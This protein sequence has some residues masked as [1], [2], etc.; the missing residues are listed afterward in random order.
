MENVYVLIIAILFLLAVFDLM[1]GV[2]NDAVNFLNSAF[3]SKVAPNWVILI[4]ASVGILVGTT[5]SSGMMEVARKGIFHPDMFAYSEIMILFLAVMLTDIILLDFYNTVALPT[6]TTVSIVF[7]LLGASVALALIKVS[8]GTAT[9]IGTFI[10]TDTA[11]K[12]MAGILLSVA[13]AF[14]LGA[15][16]QFISRL[17]F[18]FNYNKAHDYF[19]AIWGGLAITAITYFI[20]IKG[21]SG[22][23]FMTEKNVDWIMQ[24]TGQIIV[25]SFLFW[26]IVLQLLYKYLKLNIFKAIIFLG[27]FALALAFASNDLVNFIGVPLAGF[28]SFIT[29]N[30]AAGGLSPDEFTME[31]LK[32]PVQSNTLM[33]LGA[34]IIMAVTL[35]FSGKAR[36]VTQTEI[37][38]GRQDPGTE[39]FSSNALSRFI[40]RIFVSFN[41]WLMKSLPNRLVKRLNERFTSQEEESPG[42]P[43]A[44]FDLIRASVNLTV[45][46]LIISFATSLKMPLSTTYVAF[47][48]AMGTS[49]SDGAW[50]RESAAYRISG[51]ITV[52][53]GWFLTAIIGFTVAFTVGLIIFYGKTIAIVVL[54]ILDIIFII[55]T[56]K[57]Q[58]TYKMNITAVKEE[59][60]KATQAD[61]LSQVHKYQISIKNFENISNLINQ[62][63]S[64]YDEALDALENEDRK[65]LKR[66]K[67]KSIEITEESQRL[68]YTTYYIEIDNLSN[69]NIEDASYSYSKSIDFLN[70][71]T[72][73]LRTI[74]A[75]VWT[76]VDNSHKGFNES[77]KKEIDNLRLKIIEFF[78]S[79]IEGISEQDR[80][81]LQQIE[82]SRKGLLKE[83]NSSYKQQ[84]QR[85]KDKSVTLRN[86]LLFFNVLNETKNMLTHTSE[87]LR[88]QD[89]FIKVVK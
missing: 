63:Y 81:Q 3:G 88:Y 65:A 83:V 76:H 55:R 43:V 64:L 68:R 8:T 40:V 6:S 72:H 39:R 84:I 26:S 61:E 86:S 28:K 62:V 4:I 45:A 60:N 32:Q 48:V 16:V 85:I 19:A 75:S 25:Y 27:T 42:K 73:S 20:V 74:I 70:E 5:F 66:I 87:L 35:W 31:I 30:N 17:I 78:K 79:V 1:V 46:S 77:Q 15:I 89:K 44:A 9:D 38:L 54:L 67:N 53:G 13:I 50:G 56:Y 51:V 21:A 37:N 41:S 24:N 58:I 49:L 47:M 22:A 52:I 2:S 12:I 18:S 80:E 71:I 11:S 82:E 33:L 10:N 29:Y 59:T 34:G 36:R 23:S 69:S 7:E 57:L 14:A